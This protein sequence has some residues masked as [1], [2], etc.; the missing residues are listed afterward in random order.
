MKMIY[1]CMTSETFFRYFKP[2]RKK[3]IMCR[4]KSLKVKLKTLR[5]GACLSDDSGL[6]MYKI[7]IYIYLCELICIFCLKS[8][9]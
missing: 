3:N 9:H 4:E 6:E 2:T 8:F 7:L 5:I 1:Q